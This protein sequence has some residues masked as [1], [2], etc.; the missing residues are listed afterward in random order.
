MLSDTE[1]A[2]VAIEDDLIGNPDACSLGDMADMCA[3]LQE[4]NEVSRTFLFVFPHHCLVSP[5][6]CFAGNSHTPF[7]AMTLATEQDER[8]W[9]NFAPVR[10]QGTFDFISQVRRHCG[11][12][13]GG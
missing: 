2:I 4:S 7:V 1:A 3:A 10:L 13:G 6:S 9:D 5:L 12:G 11:A 8:D